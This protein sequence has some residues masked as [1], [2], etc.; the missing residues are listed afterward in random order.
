[1]AYDI[2]GNHLQPGHCEVHPDVAEPYPCTCCFEDLREYVVGEFEQIAK[3]AVDD[4]YKIRNDAAKA[5]RAY[6]EGDN[7]SEG[8]YDELEPTATDPTVN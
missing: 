2:F 5:I 3:E 6:Y 7:S 8:G 1:M 4:L